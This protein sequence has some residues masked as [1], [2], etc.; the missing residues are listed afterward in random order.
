M[1]S[2]LSPQMTHDGLLPYLC[3][4]QSVFGLVVAGELIAFAL[5]L[6]K[7]SLMHFSWSQLGYTSMV[8][9]WIVLLSAL[10]LCYLSPV[11]KRCQIWLAGSLAYG[12]VLLVS[13]V[14]ISSALWL[15]HGY[16]E[17]FNLLKNM[18][19]SG[20]FSGIILRYLYLQ[21]Q[22]RNQ[23]QAELQSRIQ[24][25][26]ARIRPHFLFNS[27]NAVA[28]LI[29]VDPDLAE[30]VVEDLSQLFR[31]SLKEAQMIPLDEELALCRSYS[32]IEQVRLGERLAFQWQ[33][34]HQHGNIFVP[35]LILQ[36]LVENAIYH[37]IQRL[38]DGGVVRIITE[39]KGKSLI[40]KV[41]NPIP[42]LQD[43]QTDTLES[44]TPTAPTKNNKKISA[45]G[46]KNNRMALDNIRH[47]LQAHYGGKAS[48]VLQQTDCD[49]TTSLCYEA[50]ITIPVS[51]A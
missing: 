23:Q 8:V 39:I 5:V 42:T 18:I 21:Q 1:R 27:M 16:I 26:H 11:F 22:L 46:N 48:I 31:A 33:C 35:S 10:V 29:A 34:E 51:E 24:A 20:I 45:K 4:G 19:L 41:I 14:V 25:L 7:G 49:S 37:G 9:Q 47:R 28:S 17:P 30:K 15:L 6:V 3:S 43:N 32:D 40:L 13:F 36:P 44:L 12:S 38:P 50:V 2:R